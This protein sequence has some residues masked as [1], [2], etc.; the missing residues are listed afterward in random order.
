MSDRYPIISVVLPA[1]NAAQFIHQIIQ[2]VLNQTFTDFELLIIDDGSMDN[3][4]VKVVYR[5]I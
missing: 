3:T 4:L 1:Y 2:S 5:H